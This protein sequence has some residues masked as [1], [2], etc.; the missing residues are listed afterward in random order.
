MR[1]GVLA[2]VHANLHALEAALRRLEAESVDAYLCAGDLV[3][4]GPLPNECVARVTALPGVCVA[5]NHDLIVLG[6]LSSDGCV[7]LARNSLAW[8]APRLSGDARAALAELPRLGVAEPG[9]LVAHGGLDDP[10]RYIRTPAE[11]A[12]ELRGLGRRIPEADVLVLGHTHEALAVGERR[13]ELLRG[14]HGTVHL[15]AGERHL[16]NPGSVGQS[17]E[18][19]AR[20]RVLVLDL[21]R[22]EATFHAVSYDVAGCRAALRRVGLPPGSCHVSPSPV[23]RVRRRVRRAVGAHGLRAGS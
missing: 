18:R 17:R 1:Y 21:E 5:G 2:D 11:A 19:R 7:P 13:G 9:V 23:A 20:A 3:G 4:Y 8:T 16:L 15:A 6:L 10:Q 12:G 22:R 14:G